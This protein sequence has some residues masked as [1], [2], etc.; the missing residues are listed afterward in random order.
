MSTLNEFISS[1]KTKGMMQTSRFDVELVLPT[2]LTGTN[3]Y[4]GDLKKV[5]LHCETAMLPGIS[6]STTQSRTYGELR[7]MPWERLYENINMSFYVDNTMH[8]KE[9]FDSWI[10]NCVQNKITRTMNY[11]ADYTTKMTVS[12]FDRKGGKR[13]STTLYECYP[14]SVS[15]IQLNQ[16]SRDIMT[17]QVSMNYKYWDSTLTTS[18]NESAAIP[19]SYFSNYPNYQTNYNSFENSRNSLFSPSESQSV[20]VGKGSILS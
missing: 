12:L 3:A 17:L 1:V 6:L 13:Y 16:A 10:N 11:Y 5:L 14:K 2:V 9:L 8:V 18:S 19:K 20:S 4:T 15:S 7:E